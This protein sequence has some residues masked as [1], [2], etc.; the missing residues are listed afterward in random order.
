[1]SYQDG[2]AALN[3]ELSRVRAA[4]GNHLPPNTPVE[5]A[6]YDNQVYEELCER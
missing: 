4:V 1:M 3:P 5:S 2:W 6:V